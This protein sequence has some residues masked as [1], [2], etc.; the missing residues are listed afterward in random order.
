MPIK[1]LKKASKTP[2][3]D[4]VKTRE[5]VQGILKDLETSKE[6][7]CIEL[8]KKFDKYDG[9]IIVSKERIEEIKKKLDQKPKMMFN[10]H[11]IELENLRKHN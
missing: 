8:T 9:E 6:N 5:L 2:S 10:F 3:T 11:M 4:D 7:G 1:Y